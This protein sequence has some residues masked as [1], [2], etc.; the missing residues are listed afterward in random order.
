[1]QVLSTN[2]FMLLISISVSV[3]K[4]SFFAELLSEGANED[5]RR[6]RYTKKSSSPSMQES[7]KS[8]QLQGEMAPVVALDE[9]AIRNKGVY[10]PMST[11]QL[12]NRESINAKRTERAKTVCLQNGLSESLTRK[13]LKTIQNLTNLVVDDKHKIMY[14]YIP[15]IGCTNWKLKLALMIGEV[16][17]TWL[18]DSLLWESPVHSKH[19]MATVGLRMLNSYTLDEMSY[20]IKN[21][22]KFV[23]V[24]YPLERLLSAYRNK[25]EPREDNKVTAK[26]FTHRFGKCGLTRNCLFL[27]ERKR[28]SHE[29]CCVVVL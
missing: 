7:T 8:D 3:L 4:L 12:A 19:G 2:N 22:Y 29:F 21:Y 1:M 13:H 23:F 15:K 18:T 20:R 26:F 5:T 16:N 9:I 14:C 28:C 11:Q 6:A 17:K 27:G 25:F 24:R 10:L